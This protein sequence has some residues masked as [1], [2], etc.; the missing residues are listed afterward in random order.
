[1]HDMYEHLVPVRITI[2]IKLQI[3]HYK[4]FVCTLVPRGY[5]STYLP[6]SDPK[7]MRVKEGS[8][9]QIFLKE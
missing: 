9:Y 3:S 2:S 7:L 5:R 8:L 6:R 4:V 1:M